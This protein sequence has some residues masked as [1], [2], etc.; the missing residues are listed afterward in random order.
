MIPVSNSVQIHLIFI[1]QI[2][3]R[4]I[5]CHFSSLF[6]NMS[7]R[8]IDSCYQALRLELKDLN[9]IMKPGGSNESVRLYKT[10]S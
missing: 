3:L 4:L 8:Q 2:T 5:P 7:P 9:R 6:C 10:S 1:Y